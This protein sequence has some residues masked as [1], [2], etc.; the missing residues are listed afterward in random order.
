MTAHK[1]SSP[2]SGGKTPM[3][4]LMVES[5]HDAAIG[6]IALVLEKIT[7]PSPPVSFCRPRLLDALSESLCSCTSTVITGRAGTGKTTLALHFAQ[8]CGRYIAWYKVDAP[9]TELRIFLQYL[10]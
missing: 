6:K 1:R 3:L 8:L 4:M 5:H 2:A 10:I 7:I 9:E